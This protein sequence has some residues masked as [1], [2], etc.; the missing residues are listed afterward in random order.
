VN[1]IRNLPPADWL[2]VAAYGFALLFVWT[3]IWG[4]SRTSLKTLAKLSIATNLADIMLSLI[5]RKMLLPSSD[6][7]A[8]PSFAQLIFG[9]EFL[10]AGLVTA[11][12][13]NKVC[14][15]KPGGE[16]DVDNISVVDPSI[17]GTHT[18][19]AWKTIS[20]SDWLW[21]LAAD[22]CYIAAFAILMSFRHLTYHP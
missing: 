9:I 18:T 8:F 7:P 11:K 19:S 5:F 4:M 10:M 3:L 17:I 20:L 14:V 21:T 13:F 15:L 6:S 12:I 22:A 16:T 1:A 2:E